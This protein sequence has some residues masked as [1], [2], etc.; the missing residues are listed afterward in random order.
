MRKVMA[1]L[2]LSAIAAFTSC[3]GGGGSDST[4][5]ETPTVPEDVT[6][7]WLITDT[8]EGSEVKLSIVIDQTAD[9]LNITSCSS[10]YGEFLGNYD[11]PT[12]AI[13]ES[14]ENVSWLLTV[15]AS[16]QANGT[17]NTTSTSGTSVAVRESESPSCGD[18]PLLGVWTDEST[19]AVL[20]IAN[21]GY[22]Y[23]HP[24][25]A[26]L[27]EGLYAVIDGKIIFYAGAHNDDRFGDVGY[28]EY[29]GTTFTFYDNDTTLVTEDTNNGVTTFT[30]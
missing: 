8:V 28:V 19:G 1:L 2:L 7:R 5:S 16:A 20:T 6:G 21:I 15:D 9:V 11:N 10:G 24:D 13:S 27:E 26:Y 14:L 17:W 3:G 4:P 30:K 29:E 18:A 25:R 22:T 12:L 23:S